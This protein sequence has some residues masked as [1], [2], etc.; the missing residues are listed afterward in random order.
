MEITQRSSF[1]MSVVREVASG[2][3][4]PAAMQR[5][6]VWEKADVEAMC[7]SIMSGFPIG[8]FLMWN[9]GPKA[10]LT[11]LA[12]GRLG[13]LKPAAA[14]ASGYNPY[15]LLLDGQNRTAT[16]A[17][18]MLRDEDAPPDSA[19]LSPA[20][21]A[22]WM[23]GER[24]VLDFETRSVKFVPAGEAAAGL[25]LPAWMLFSNAA[26]STRMSA[27]A[28]MRKLVREVWPKYATQ[29]TI[30]DFYDLWD[31]ACNRFREART[32]ETII[33]G[34]SP[35]EARHAFIRICRVGV[36]MSQEDFDRAIGWTPGA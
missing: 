10:D 35:A 11:Q 21:Q 23:S 33:E 5:P 34:A 28:H 17:W 31:H 26:Q 24:M 12:K 1:L 22:T 25:R 18:M 19:D 16:M 27:N 9:P 6:Y 7:D 36:P 20:E 30:D 15:S 3:M 29:E 14:D 8:A 13:P 2:R 32:T 4:L